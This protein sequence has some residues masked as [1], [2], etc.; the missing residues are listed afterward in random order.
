MGINVIRLSELL[1]KED[2]EYTIAFPES[3][4]LDEI[5]SYCRRGVQ[6]GEH[7]YAGALRFY[8]TSKLIDTHSKKVLNRYFTA[9]LRCWIG[10]KKL[11]TN[12]AYSHVLIHHGIY[13][14]QGV[15]A[16]TA[17]SFELPI[18]TWHTAYHEKTFFFSHAG[19]YH[20]TILSEPK[21][22]WDGFEF[23]DE[24]REKILNYLKSLVRN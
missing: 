10:A 19:T 8:A 20:K 17:I 23:T 2:L 4:K 12:E 15:F 3:L 14:P 6:I 1:T 11:F 5:K 9:A 22:S 7:A 21:G 16:E 24:K 18:T 13:V